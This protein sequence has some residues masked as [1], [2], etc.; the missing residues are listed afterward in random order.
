MVSPFSYYVVKILGH[1]E[2]RD[3]VDVVDVVNG[4]AVRGGDV[5]ERGYLG[6]LRR[7]PSKDR[8]ED[9][10]RISPVLILGLCLCL[11]MPVCGADTM[12]RDAS[13]Y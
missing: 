2:Q 1:E 6:A 5:A 8:S 12:V 7:T 11:C 10:R 9:Q 13:S 4:D 3:V